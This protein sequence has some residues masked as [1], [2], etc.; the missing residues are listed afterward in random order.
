MPHRLDSSASR[1]RASRTERVRRYLNGAGVAREDSDDELGLEDLP[2]EWI[3]GDQLQ[4]EKETYSHSAAGYELVTTNR[5]RKA[6]DERNAYARRD[7]L[8]A[9]LGSFECRVGDC[10]LLK[11]DGNNEA[12]VGLICEFL[13][14]EE[15]G[16]VA[17][18]M[19][20][21]T[22]KEIRNKEKKIT[23]FMQVF[24]T[25]CPLNDHCTQT[26]L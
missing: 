8:G 4:A 3:Y 23:D 26:N 2:W 21:S 10:V 16:K 11:A 9:R 7:I 22:E 1:K 15:E 17:N 19:W 24:Q 20:F 18:F 12:W 25:L 13:E 6:S 14:D 5:K